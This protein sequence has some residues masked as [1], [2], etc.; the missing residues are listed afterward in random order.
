MTSNERDGGMGRW[1]RWRV[2]GWSMAALLLLLPVAAMRFT[3]EVDW[4]AGDF[5]FAA[6]LIGGVGAAFEGAIRA[7]RSR[8]YH[9]GAA[10]ALGAA[11]LTVWANGA[12]GMIGAP[13]NPLNIM[14]AGVLAIALLGAVLARFEPRGLARAMTMAAIAQLS[15]SAIGLSADIRGGIASGLLAGIWL[16]SARSFSNA[17]SV[18]A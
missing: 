15:A 12:V 8:A 16:L 14:F 7:S 2:A 13:H 18:S 11:A 1:S 4:T 3:E 9:L 17:A 5:A 6:L 10:L